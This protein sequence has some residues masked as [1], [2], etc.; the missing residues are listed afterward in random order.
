MFTFTDDCRIGIEQIDDEHEYL[1]KILNEAFE[2]QSD[3]GVEDKYNRIY[4]LI[5]QLKN[6]AHIHFKHEEEYMEKIS[7]PELNLQKKQHREFQNKIDSLLVVNIEEKQEQVLSDI[8]EY[9]TRWLYRHILSSDM[10]IGKMQS[11]EE[12]K[13]KKSPCAFTEEYYT[14]IEQV[15]KDHKRLFEIIEEADNVIKNE[16]IPDK[17]DNIVQLLEQLTEYTKFHFANEEKYM[18]EIGYPGLEAQ[19]RAHE[20]FVDKLEQIEIGGYDEN[21]QEILIELM[22]FLFSWLV[23]HI[24]KADKLIPVK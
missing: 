13:A 7:D 10:M 19:K 3:S 5:M 9:M 16:Y 12:W 24:L 8:L 20:G 2:L 6:Y 17:F 15:D 14:G 23:N 22:D 21:Q 18:E 1:F 11:V 4:E